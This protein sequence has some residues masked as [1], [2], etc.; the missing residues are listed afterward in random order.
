M[1]VVAAV[2]SYCIGGGVDLVSACDIRLASADAVFSVREVDERPTRVR[3]AYT[4]VR[5][6]AA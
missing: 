5:C 3:A 2:H 6:I 4:H 1:P